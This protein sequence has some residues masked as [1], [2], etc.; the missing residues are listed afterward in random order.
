MNDDETIIVIRHDSQKGETYVWL[1]TDETAG[2]VEADLRRLWM[3]RRLG[4][5]ECC[6]IAAAVGKAMVRV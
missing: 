1:L 5:R 4:F 6:R 2:T 3:E